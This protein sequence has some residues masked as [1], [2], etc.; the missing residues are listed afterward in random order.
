MDRLRLRLRKLNQFILFYPWIVTLVVTGCVSEPEQPEGIIPKNVMIRA[1]A[2]FHL[3]DANVSRMNF[4]DLDSAK[5]A[6]HYFEKKIYDK[7]HVDSATYAKSYQFYGEHPQLMLEIYQSV[8]QEL[9]LKK[10]S[11]YQIKMTK[12]S[13]PIKASS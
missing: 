9:E 11:I 2:D 6:F 8:S 4:V 10:D 13:K 1:I 12:P 7:Y 5:I 3:L